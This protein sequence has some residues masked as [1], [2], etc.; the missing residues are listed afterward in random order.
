MHRK[1][2]HSQRRDCGRADTEDRFAFIYFFAFQYK[3]VDPPL[4][5]PR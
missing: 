5:N 1:L 3:K 4:V 2:K